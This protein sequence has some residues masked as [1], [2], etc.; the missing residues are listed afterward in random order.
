MQG[1]SL[2]PELASNAISV[3]PGGV[4]NFQ[5]LD[6]RF[7]NILAFLREKLG[8]DFNLTSIKLMVERIIYDDD[9]AYI[10]GVIMRRDPDKRNRWINAD[11]F[12]Q[13]KKR[14]ANLRFT[15]DSFN[16]FNAFSRSVPISALKASF[17]E[18]ASS[19]PRFPSSAS[20]AAPKTKIDALPRAR[21]VK[22]PS[23]KS[24]PAS[25]CVTVITSFQESCGYHFLTEC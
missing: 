19:L 24:S 20:L 2:T 21:S 10:A 1:R 18:E 17:K 11:Y 13:I 22:T 8:E 6:A 16:S 7:Y 14:T 4:V 15:N 25:N 12:D 3:A 23:V 5:V 9:T